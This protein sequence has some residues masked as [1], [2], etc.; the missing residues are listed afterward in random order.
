MDS[1]CAGELLS[2]GSNDP[3][4]HVLPSSGVS[5]VQR[6][7]NGRGFGRRMLK[8]S[9]LYRSL[10]NGADELRGGMDASQYKDYV[11]TR[12]FA[13]E[14]GKSKGQFYTPAEI[15]MILARVVG[16]GT[17]TSVD[18]TVYDPTCGSGSLLL[19]AASE[20][21]GGMSAYGQEM[22]NATFALAQ[23]NL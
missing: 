12:L 4:D 16:I 18:Q 8:K 17:T 10:W 22:D 20:A 7:T 5:Q 6:P 13:T 19:K 11:L 15:S 1:G 9:D 2:V 3:A 23:M 14:S 21:P